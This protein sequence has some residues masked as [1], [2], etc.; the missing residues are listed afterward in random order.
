[1]RD[2]IRLS[3]YTAVV[4]VATIILQIYTPATRG[5]FN[6]GEA[7]IYT[8]AYMA[9]PLVAGIASGVG[10]ALADLLTGYGVFAP[11]TLVIK[12]TEGYIVSL[13]MRRLARA[14]VLRLRIGSVLTAVATGVV[15]GVTGSVLWSGEVEI[16]SVPLSIMGIE[17]TL[18]STSLT[19]GSLVW[20]LIGLLVTV[21]LLYMILVRGRENLSTALSIVAGGLVMP[22]GYLLYEYFVSNPLQNIPPEAAFVELPINIGQMIAGFTISLSVISFIRRAYE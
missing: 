7:A 8:I 14:G 2:E 18:L 3:V 20:A 1:M 4:L 9:T 19:I 11:G 17:T 15:I 5:Y 16:T 12:F 13:L 10:S 21:F 6:L 22:I